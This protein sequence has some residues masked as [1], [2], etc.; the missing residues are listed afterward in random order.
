M[1]SRR[2]I[3]VVDDETIIASTLALILSSHGFDA[4]PY[5]D[6]YEALRAAET[7]SPDLLLTDVAMPKLNGIDLA[8]QFK[9]IYPDC[10]VLL[11]SGHTSTGGMLDSARDQG[12]NFA[13]LS[14]P[15][16]P[17]DLIATIKSMVS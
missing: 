17:Q 11:F 13:L 6:P 9:V 12:H 8:V 14:K 3:F 16:Q 5:T 7:S 1:T 15:V 4:V 2:R 10:K